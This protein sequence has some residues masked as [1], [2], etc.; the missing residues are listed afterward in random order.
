MVD[1][2]G[3]LC[4][5]DRL[6][7]FN[8]IFIDDLGFLLCD[9]NNDYNVEEIKEMNWVWIKCFFIIFFWV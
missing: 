9:E 6:V 1:I 3:F 5:I 4:F 2:F 8:I 7:E